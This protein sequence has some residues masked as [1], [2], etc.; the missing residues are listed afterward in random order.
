MKDR[1]GN[2]LKVGDKVN[3]LEQG[4]SP[5]RGGGCCYGGG[6]GA[7]YLRLGTIVGFDNHFSEPAAIL[8][9]K[10]GCWPNERLNTTTRNWNEM[11]RAYEGVN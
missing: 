8:E 7:A 4:E 3:F 11:A 1:F 9:Y 2:N 6:F 10:T 5:D